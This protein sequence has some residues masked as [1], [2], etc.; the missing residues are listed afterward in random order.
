VLIGG[1]QLLDRT[2]PFILKAHGNAVL[3]KTPQFFF[4]A[5]V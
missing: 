3:P 1:Y 2:V 4:E 5:I